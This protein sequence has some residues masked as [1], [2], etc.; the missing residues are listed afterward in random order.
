MY[1]L[2]ESLLGCGQV[3]YLRETRIETNERMDIMYQ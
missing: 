3:T 2:V 1:E